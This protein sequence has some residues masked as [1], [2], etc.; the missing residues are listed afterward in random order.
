MQVFF[1][2]HVQVVI[3][4]LSTVYVFSHDFPWVPSGGGCPKM[5]IYS[6]AIVKKQGSC[7][8]FC[9]DTIMIC[10]DSVLFQRAGTTS[11]RRGSLSFNKGPFLVLEHLWSFLIPEEPVLEQGLCAVSMS[12]VSPGAPSAFPHSWLSPASQMSSAFQSLILNRNYS[13]YCQS[14]F[15][16][17]G[18]KEY[19]YPQLAIIKKYMHK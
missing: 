15:V 8:N 7:S 14:Y 13:N 2:V 18:T 11:L 16:I 17:N 9:T 4:L 19:F 12:F 6:N 10:H 5:L 3:F 1:F